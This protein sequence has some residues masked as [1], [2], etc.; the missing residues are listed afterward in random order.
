MKLHEMHMSRQ[1]H[2]FGA[3]VICGLC[4]FGDK[5]SGPRVG[6]FAQILEMGM[7]FFI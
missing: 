7:T 4:G 6:L 3:V 1:D 2:G 5:W